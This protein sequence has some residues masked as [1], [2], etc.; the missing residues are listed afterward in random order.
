MTQKDQE[1]SDQMTDYLTNFAKNG[2]PNGAGL[3]A[4]QAAQISGKKVLRM[5]EGNTCMGAANMLKLVKTMLT[6]KAV[7]E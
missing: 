5:G 2:D 4:W 1:L 3:P 6:N 7:G